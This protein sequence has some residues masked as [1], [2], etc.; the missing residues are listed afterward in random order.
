[1][2]KTYNFAIITITILLSTIVSES[3]AQNFNELD[4]VPHDISY[5]RV[6]RVTPPLVKVVYGRPQKNDVE[7][8]GNIVPYNKLWRTGAN[9]ATEIKFYK[10]VLFGETMVAAG[11]YV[12]V[13]IPGENEWEIILNSKLDVIGAFQYNPA[14]DIAK[15]KVPTSNAESLESFSIAFKN[16]EDNLQMVLGWD[17]IRVKIPPYFEEESVLVER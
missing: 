8:F 3:H 17:N 13:T 11:T 1:M 5:Y 12:L 6:N 15:I 10:D 14:Y 7:V 4:K 2:K 9:E 16:Q